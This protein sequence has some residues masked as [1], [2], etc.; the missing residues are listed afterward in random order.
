[1]FDQE[2]DVQGR[3]A[4]LWVYP[5]KSCA[6]IA[7]QSSGVGATGLAW[8]RHWMVVDANGEFL[9]QRDHPRMAWIRPELEAG[10]LVLHFP[11]LPPLRIPL[12][13]TG[14]VRQARVWSD[15]V[16]AWD[17]GPEAA[18]WL[19]Q[20]LGAD[21]ALVRFD[22]AAP[23]RASE[24]WTGGE[25]A[26]VHFADG[27]PLLVL[28]QAAVDELNQRLQAAGQPAVDARRFRPNIVIEG[29][30]AHDEDRVD[31]FDVL[32]ARG[33]RLRMAKPCTRCPIPDIDPV[34][35]VQGTA[36]GDAIRA[37]R[38]DD[39]VDGAITFGMNAVLEGLHDGAELAVGQ[40]VAGDWQFA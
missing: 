15:G 30:E 22:P 7:L 11:Q 21:C 24:R 13:A 31:G 17:M 5:V 26:P 16:Q 29:L 34:T 9:T 27:Y 39:R 19:T 35:A 1:M 3:I 8:D 4:Q 25:A 33:L 10:H 40:S 23:R 14:P 12:Q 32:D 38:Q 28:S 18:R 2:R 20:A 36:V 37:Y 6:G